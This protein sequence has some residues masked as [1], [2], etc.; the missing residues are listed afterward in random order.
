MVLA[1]PATYGGIA[2]IFD[3]NGYVITNSFDV[4]QITMYFEVKEKVGD[5]YQINRYPKTYYIYYSNT[6]TVKDFKITFTF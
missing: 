3:Q 6:N 5:S 4:K 2:H 1:L